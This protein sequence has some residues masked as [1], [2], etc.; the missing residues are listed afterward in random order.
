MVLDA[1][2]PEGLVRPGLLI[3]NGILA[4]TGFTVLPPTVAWAPGHVTAE[5]R[6]NILTTTPN[7][8]VESSRSNHYSSIP[9]RTTTAPNDFYLASR[10]D[11]ESSGTPGAGQ[12]F[13][14]TA[15]D[16]TH[17]VHP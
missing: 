7:A 8:G 17:S 9:G 12:T 2:D 15:D 13:A 11:Q 14:S 5:E 3:H 4:Y 10:P 6:Q 1:G 16:Y